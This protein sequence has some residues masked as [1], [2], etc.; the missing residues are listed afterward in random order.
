MHKIAFSTKNY[1]G[2][3]NISEDFWES[4]IAI[5]LESF[6]LPVKSLGNTFGHACKSDVN[7]VNWYEMSISVVGGAIS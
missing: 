2:R 1:L 5:H 4:F 3:Q 7:Y 6:L